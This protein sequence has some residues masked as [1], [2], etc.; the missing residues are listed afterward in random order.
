M[1][2]GFGRYSYPPSLLPKLFGYKGV[3]SSGLILGQL[4]EKNTPEY[5]FAKNTFKTVTKPIYLA[6]ME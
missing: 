5:F 1:P 3:L 6:V 2:G 4:K